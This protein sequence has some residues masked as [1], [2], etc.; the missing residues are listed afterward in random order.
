MYQ[1]SYHK[2]LKSDS[3]TIVY[4]ASNER[5]LY[6][7]EYG[8]KIADSDKILS[9]DY[10]DSFANLQAFRN[11][12]TGKDGSNIEV[13]NVSKTMSSLCNCK[14]YEYCQ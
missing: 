3:T 12:V 13:V 4:S 1:L 2:N 14:D 10:N 7:D 5:I 8:H 6:V 11:A 9:N